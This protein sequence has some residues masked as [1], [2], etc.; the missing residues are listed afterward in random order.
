MRFRERADRESLRHLLIIALVLLPLFALNG[1]WGVEGNPD[2]IAVAVAAWQLAEKGTLDLSEHAFIRDHLDELQT[3]Y[4]QL[5]DGRI[6]S[7]RAPGL[8]GLATPMYVLRGDKRFSYAP[9]TFVAWIT[10]VLAMLVTWSVLKPLVGRA[11]AT[12]STFVLALGTTTWY[13]SSSE[14]WPHGP[15]QLWAALALVGLAS[16]SWLIAGMSFALSILTRPVTGVLAA[17]SGIAE[18][19]RTK[20]WGFTVKAGAIASV[21]LGLVLLYNRWLFGSWSVRGGYSESF[22]SGALER[23]TVGGYLRNLFDMLLD[24]RI[25]VLITSPI[26]GVSVYAAIKAWSR[27]PGW[28]KSA[29]YAA[30]AYLL[31]H[32]LLNHASGDM[33]VFY[34]YPLEAIMFAI[35]ALVVGAQ[36]LWQRDRLGRLL[37]GGSAIISV[38]LQVLHVFY[39]SCYVTGM[40]SPACIL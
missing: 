35:P 12:G 31:V 27:I 17:V 22:T 10:T 21:G 11:F 14:L 8:I 3:W 5:D 9:A 18:G 28:A 36:H 7:N 24:I 2:G 32:A 29:S 30:V 25:G 23:F 39:L 33:L 1:R 13:I 37:V 6:V 26:I 16:G 34:R 40:G 19:I 20:Q 15:G 38:A 4:V